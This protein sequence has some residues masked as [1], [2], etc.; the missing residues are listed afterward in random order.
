MKEEAYQDNSN[1]ISLLSVLQAYGA[2]F[3][4]LPW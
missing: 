2:A 4:R 1:L 3:G